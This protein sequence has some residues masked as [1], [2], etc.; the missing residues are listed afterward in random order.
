[1]VLFVVAV[2]VLQ[3]FG[4]A[5]RLFERFLAV[6]GDHQ[7]RLVFDDEV[8]GAL[9]EVAVAAL[10]PVGSEDEVERT[11]SGEQVERVVLGPVVDGCRGN[12]VPPGSLARSQASSSSKAERA[13]RVPPVAGRGEVDIN[14]GGNGEIVKLRCNATDDDEPDAVPVEDPDD[15]RDV[16]LRAWHGCG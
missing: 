2:E 10:G 8:H 15:R 12:Q 1:V 7:D 13:A 3:V 5:R 11:V 6:D 4:A 9:R 14:S 16:E